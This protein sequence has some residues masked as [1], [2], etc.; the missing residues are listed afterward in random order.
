VIGGKPTALGVAARLRQ[1]A[2]PTVNEENL[3]QTLDE[4]LRRSDR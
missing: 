1:M 4:L 3:Y 2:A